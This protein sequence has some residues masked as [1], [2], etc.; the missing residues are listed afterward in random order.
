MLSSYSSDMVSLLH[1][2]GCLFLIDS[3][4]FLCVHLFLQ[5]IIGKESLLVIVGFIFRCRNE[6]Y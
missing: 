3:L 2:H 6:F 5:F 1:M 4:S